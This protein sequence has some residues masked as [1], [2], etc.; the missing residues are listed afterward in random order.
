MNNISSK[1]SIK[2]RFSNSVHK[3]LEQ[4]IELPRSKRWSHKRKLTDAEKVELFNKIMILHDEASEEYSKC[5]YKYREAKRV[6]KARE[7]RKQGNEQKSLA[8]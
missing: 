6:M 4:N 3:L 5:G 1:L 8:V 7:L 2:L